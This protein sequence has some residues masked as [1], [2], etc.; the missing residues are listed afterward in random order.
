[1]LRR[2]ESGHPRGRI[3][4]E[5]V[6]DLLPAL[7]WSEV[8]PPASLPEALHGDRRAAIEPEWAAPMLHISEHET[9]YRDFG[10]FTVEGGT[11]L[12]RRVDV[13]SLAAERM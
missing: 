11:V 1:M 10:L 3:A 9:E 12:S 4:A 6:V 13:G 5:R 8:P 7:C 2:Q